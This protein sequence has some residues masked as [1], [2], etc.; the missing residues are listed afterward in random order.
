MADDKN[1]RDFRDRGRTATKENYELSFL[2]KKMGVSRSQIER[3]I[4]VV[5]NDRQK[6]EKYL[7]NNKNNMDRRDPIL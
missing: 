5:G 7:R 2:E 3:A 6:V 1:Q 4:R